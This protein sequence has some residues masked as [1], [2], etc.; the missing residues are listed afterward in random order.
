MP[1]QMCDVSIFITVDFEIC[2]SDRAHDRPRAH[3]HSYTCKL[4]LFFKFDLVCDR[5]LLGGLV[6]TLV[7]FGQGC[8][9]VL[10]SIFSD[11]YVTKHD[12][13]RIVVV[14]FL[15]VVF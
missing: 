15:F 14:V 5:K 10:S 11:R 13:N 2:F 3:T 12:F 9:A 6:Q 4:F 1:S 7:I 8:G